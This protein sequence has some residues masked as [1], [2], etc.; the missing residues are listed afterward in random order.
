MP[1][2]IVAFWASFNGRE[3][4]AGFLWF[5]GRVGGN[6]PTKTRSRR[7]LNAERWTSGGQQVRTNRALS[8]Y[9]DDHLAGA[10]VG[11]ELAQRSL[12]SHEGTPAAGPLQT[13]ADEIAD[14]RQ[15]LIWVQQRLG[16]EP[17]KMKTAA[18][19]ISEKITRFK[20]SQRITSDPN[21]TRLLELETLSLGIAGKRALWQSLQSSIGANLQDVD[22]EDLIKRAERQRAR[23][24]R[25][26]LDAAR[27][28]FTG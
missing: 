9:L 2:G 7:R 26:R 16:F 10:T 18:G 21:F 23:V 13:L 15:T 1:P 12:S 27:A 3:G 5:F 8:T 6:D 20:L 11:V 17:S 14:D 4:T 22:F 25:Y 19:R 28:A 24:E